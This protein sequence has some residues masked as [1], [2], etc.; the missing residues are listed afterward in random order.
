MP[1]QSHLSYVAPKDI[2]G[3]TGQMS[4]KHSYYHKGLL[5]FNASR[6]S[7]QYRL[8]GLTSRGPYILL[9]ADFDILPP[10]FSDWNCF[11]NYCKYSYPSGCVMKTFSGK[12]KVA[13]TVKTS[14][15]NKAEQLRSYLLDIIGNDLYEYLDLTVSGMTIMF[16]DKLQSAVLYAYSCSGKHLE[17]GI[18]I[19]YSELDHSF[20][21]YVGEL[22]DFAKY[23]VES[24][25]S[26][27]KKRE[28]FI[29][30][31][32]MQLGLAKSGFDLPTTKLGYEIDVPPSR[33]SEWLRS[34]MR[35]KLLKCIDEKYKIG[36]KA[37]TYK[38]VGSMLNY[39]KI[40]FFKALKT[41]TNYCSKN[42]EKMLPTYIQDGDWN[43]KVWELSKHFV[44]FPSKFIEYGD[45]LYGSR[46]KRRIKKFI[47]AI[48]SRLKYKGLD[49]I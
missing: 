8:G 4:W 5:F 23:W 15:A 14:G 7:G 1:D 24:G 36:F 35:L 18:D 26:S 11:Y 39:M 21:S 37:K 48:N 3:T 27:I 32:L 13:F 44:E 25:R 41:T 34:L 22:P 20:K 30:I 45:S 31:V 9:F 47:S 46:Y 17:V 28:K 40:T 38:A 10:G 12:V 6:K 33:I 16:F 43:R 42:I 2:K 29:R 49:L 19:G